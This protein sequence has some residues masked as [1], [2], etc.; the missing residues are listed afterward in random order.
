[1]LPKN[2]KLNCLWENRQVCAWDSRKVRIIWEEMNEDESFTEVCSVQIPPPTLNCMKYFQ[3][4]H[5]QM[6][7]TSPTALIPCTYFRRHRTLFSYP[8]K[9]LI[10][11]DVPEDIQRIETLCSADEDDP[12]GSR[13]V[14][15]NKHT[16][17]SKHR[18]PL[19]DRGILENNINTTFW[20]TCS[21]DSAE[22]NLLITVATEWLQYLQ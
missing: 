22:R 16:L 18:P 20:G 11:V 4:T 7:T 17:S 19:E 3:S 12:F 13:S 6:D 21:K 5:K 15:S 14:A 8:V 10:K 9:C 1:M 2:R